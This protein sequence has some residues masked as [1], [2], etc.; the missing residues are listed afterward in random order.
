MS[1]QTA[2]GALFIPELLSEFLGYL[3]GS[4]YG[5]ISDICAAGLACTAWREPAEAIRWRETELQD[6]LSMLVETTETETEEWVS[7][8]H[9]L[10][11]KGRSR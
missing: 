1:G 3:Y 4:E 9:A 2:H 10:M 8:K 5:H 7:H 11:T 6:I